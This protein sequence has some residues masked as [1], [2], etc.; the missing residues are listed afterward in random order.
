MEP[1][2]STML[3]R[4]LREQF[5]VFAEFKPLK[6]GIREELAARDIA[7]VEHLNKALSR[8]TGDRRYLRNV[9]AGGARYGLDG[10][11]CGTI[12]PLE[13]GFA[14]GRLGM[15][16]DALPGLNP[17]TEKKILEELAMR[18]NTVKVSV[19]VIDFEQHLDVD[20]I[21]AS[22]VPVTV[23][24]ATGKVKA[25]LNPKSFRKAQAAF[26]ELGGQ[27]AVLITGEFDLPSAT[28]KAAG[29]IVQPKKSKEAPA[30]A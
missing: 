3:L 12:S 2:P 11:V 4:R 29:I 30:G 24:T 8:Q 16:L 13:R 10:D 21:G 22:S 20:S 23:E 19:T 17:G 28:I 27:A 9:V 26:K 6:L 1:Q 5:P 18:A 7:P 14:A 15:K 25:V